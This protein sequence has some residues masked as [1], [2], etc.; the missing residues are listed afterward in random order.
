VRAT[1]VEAVTL[2]FVVVVAVCVVA[3]GWTSLTLRLQA[4]ERVQACRDNLLELGDALHRYTLARKGR[5][6]RTLDELVP[7]FISQIPQCPSGTGTEGYGYSVAAQMRYTVYCSGLRHD[8]AGLSR[9]NP[10][11]TR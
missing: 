1:T 2:L 9:D 11:L 3:P 4:A 10:Y 7:R 5:L 8:D 6:P